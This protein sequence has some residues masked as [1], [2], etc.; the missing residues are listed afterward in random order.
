MNLAINFPSTYKIVLNVI[1]ELDNYESLINFHEQIFEV[2]FG[3]KNACKLDIEE[4]QLEELYIFIIYL[5]LIGGLDLS[6]YYYLNQIFL[7]NLD[8]IN[9]ELESKN[10]LIEKA[11]QDCN[12]D[13]L[14]IKKSFIK[15]FENKETCISNKNNIDTLA[16][17]T[18]NRPEI[19]KECILAYISNFQK[20]YHKD[21]KI[22]IFDDS[23]F[24]YAKKNKIIVEEIKTIYPNLIYLDKFKKNE[25]IN[26]LVNKSIQKI[27]HL[28]MKMIK[29]YIYY[30]FGGNE[31]KSSYGRNR[32][33][34]SF[35]LK[36]K[37]YISVDDDSK[38]IVLTCKKNILKQFIQ[39]AIKEKV[40]FENILNFDDVKEDDKQFVDVD[41]L[42]YF[43]SSENYTAQYLKYSG[44]K[45]CE[46]YYRFLK[47]MGFKIKNVEKYTLASKMPNLISNKKTLDNYKRNLDNDVFIYAE[48]EN[49]KLMIK[50]L[51]SF[52]PKS[53]HKL[54]VSISE[55]LRIEDLCLGANSFL[56]TNKIPIEANFALYH[57]KT[58]R[59][60][61]ADEI[62]K[63]IISSIIYSVYIA[64]IKELGL[65]A[66]LKSLYLFYQRLDKPIF[67]TNEAF[68]VYK[69]TKKYVY[70]LYNNCL[71]ISVKNKN[72][73]TANKL[74]IIIKDLEQEFFSLNDSNSK[75]MI[76]KF[77][78]H[79]IKNY[80]SSMIL[81]LTLEYLY[82]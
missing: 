57:Q 30:T 56:T 31:F 34:I 66:N 32:N 59:N 5:R 11:I 40:S 6:I 29:Y 43:K 50:G 69:I 25:L 17:L 39:K 35:Y 78:H 15:S 22:I 4:R 36:G 14:E 71:D 3:L 52:Y 54:N 67:I 23:D 42:E 19:L 24:F 49:D 74:K 38:P 81:F 13:N 26:G 48:K 44:D 1:K 75:Q 37:N 10:V 63:E 64:F 16:I 20:F 76:E 62:H 7:V 41:F 70:E 79:I 18:C 21:I 8:S 27:S 60:I 55:N 72:F 46:T 80:I 58:E 53:I 77:T 47:Q 73:E 61:S 68:E 28:D 65:E 2:L 45:D 12:C 51:C 9:H 82:F 33:F